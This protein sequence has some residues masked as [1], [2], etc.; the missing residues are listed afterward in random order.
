MR[1]VALAVLA[2]VETALVACV[3]CALILGISVALVASPGVTSGLVR[4]NRT[5]IYT[6]LSETTTVGLADRVR[7]Y[8]VGRASESSG[9]STALTQ[10]APGE[11][12]HLSDVR[13]V[14][15]GARIATGGASAALALWLVAALVWRRW[16]RLRW[17][18]AAGGW[19]AI[20]LAAVVATIAAVNFEGAFT[21]FHGL[22]FAPGTWEFPSNSLLIEVFPAGFW[23]SAGA[24]WGGLT[25]LGGVALVVA[26]RFMPSND[27][28]AQEVSRER[29]ARRSAVAAR[30]ESSS[31]G[32]KE[33]GHSTDVGPL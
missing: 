27:A 2:A 17:G 28:Q 8:V 4:L 7:A 23:V 33:S 20:G 15:T 25:A 21:V 22:F 30:E 14:M 9:T 18:I 16:R 10:F 1:R 5:W 3:F 32:H 19:L 12:A 6:G 29:D 13:N 11:V 26:S 31:A 24:L